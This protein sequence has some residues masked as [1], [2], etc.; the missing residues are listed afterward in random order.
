MDSSADKKKTEKKSGL[1]TRLFALTALMSLSG[2]VGY[3]SREGY[4]AATDSFVA[5]IILSP[6]NDLVLQNKMKLSELAVERARIVAQIEAT[7]ADL[8]ACDKG[9]ARLQALHDNAGNALA[10][11][12]SM[13][14]QAAYAA[15]VESRALREQEKVISQMLAD[16]KRFATETQSDVH[17][18]L[19]AKS[20]LARETQTVNQLELALLENSR[21]QMQTRQQQAQAAF[22]Q[23]SLAKKGAPMMPEMLS[24]EEQ[25]V[26]LELEMMRLDAEKRAKG[27]EQRV[28]QDKLAKIDEIDAQ[29][30]GRPIYRAVEQSMD[31]AFV[32]YTQIDGVRNGAE[33]YDCVWGIF[34]CK[35]VGKVTEIVPGEV[36]LPDPW[37]NQA[38]GQFA[39]LSLSEHE[40][41]KAKTLRVRGNNIGG[42]LIT[43]SSPGEGSSESTLSLLGFGNSS[44]KAKK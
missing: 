42:K 12:T 2:G 30:R 7:A 21:S 26:R 1:K 13:S 10:W 23:R 28:L 32:P 8:S 6:D 40:S 15:A 44:S 43:P 24:R 20:E 27:V 37:G 34:H 31:I 4:H 36:I 16:Q 35:A 38:R 41:A 3:V 14:Q 11:T 22:A 25:M 5:P 9:L 19:V 29:L 17:A 39:V 18:G 33:V